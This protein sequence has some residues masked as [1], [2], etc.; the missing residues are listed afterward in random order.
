MF[1]L[2][3][4]PSITHKTSLVYKP[5]GAILST[6]KLT[7]EKFLKAQKN[8]PKSHPEPPAKSHF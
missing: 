1:T 7:F 5:F 6:T 4:Y 2:R 8:S 3:R